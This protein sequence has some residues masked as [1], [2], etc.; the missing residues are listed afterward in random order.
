MIHRHLKDDI[1]TGLSTFP[2]IALYGPRQV[3]K[4]TIAREIADTRPSLFLDL[5]NPRHELMLQDP[6]TVCEG[7]ADKLIVLDEV[8]RKPEL[9]PVLRVL[10]DQDRRPGRFLLLGSASPVLSCD[11]SHCSVD[12]AS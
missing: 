6:L 12:V 7:H 5:E 1:E 11:L 2:V 9:F 10:V 3:G 4:S 8:Q